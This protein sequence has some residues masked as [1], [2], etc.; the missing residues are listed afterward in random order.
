MKV[1]IKSGIAVFGGT[2]AVAVAAGFGAAGVSPAGGGAA[3]PAAHSSSSS[4]PARTEASAAGV[5]PA[6]L[7]SC[8]SGLDC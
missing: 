1:Q 8:V 6:T 7:A 4:A 3:P 5:H 2:V